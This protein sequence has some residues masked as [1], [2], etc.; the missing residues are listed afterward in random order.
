MRGVSGIKTDERDEAQEEDNG[1]NYAKIG[2]T[3]ADDDDRQRGKK[4]NPADV[5][6]KSGYSRE[7]E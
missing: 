6:E 4:C 3:K 5:E 1:R 7:I 2:H